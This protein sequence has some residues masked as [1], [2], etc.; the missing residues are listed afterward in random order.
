VRTTPGIPSDIIKECPLYWVSK[1]LWESIE[2]CGTYNTDDVRGVHFHAWPT[3]VHGICHGS[4]FT[5]IYDSEDAAKGI[6]LSP[7]TLRTS[8]VLWAVFFKLLIS[9]LDLKR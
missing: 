2:L 1:L 4:I 5:I 6:N 3:A 8:S 7:C 9:V